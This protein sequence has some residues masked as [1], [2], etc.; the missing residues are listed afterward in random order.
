MRAR[1]DTNRSRSGIDQHSRSQTG[2][3]SRIW[4]PPARG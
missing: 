1:R 3:R 4:T 2:E